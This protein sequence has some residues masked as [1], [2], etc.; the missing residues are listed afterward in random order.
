MTDDIGHMSDD[1]RVE[2]LIQD[3]ITYLRGT[4]RE[5]H[6]PKCMPY[7]EMADAVAAL[8]AENAKLHEAL[9]Y[10]GKILGPL[11]E[12]TGLNWDFRSD[13]DEVLAR[14]SLAL[15]KPWG[16]WREGGR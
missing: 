14:V 13:V 8:K 3:A 7:H 10:A 15:N 4:R 11:R 6:C 1:D 12:H 5:C 16:F 9:R 2:E